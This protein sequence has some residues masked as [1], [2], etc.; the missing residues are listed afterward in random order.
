MKRFSQWYLL[1]LCSVVLTACCTKELCVP[2]LQI[3]LQNYTP[4]EIAQSY[5]LG[6]TQTPRLDSVRFGDNGIAFISDISESQVRVITPVDTTTIK[7]LFGKV[8][9]NDCGLW[10]TR[11]RT[12]AGYELAGKKMD[13]DFVK[14]TRP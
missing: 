2:Y 8:T 12:T 14:I 11:A 5:V 6:K 7:V 1:A 13:G 3:Q 9:C 4:K 10:K